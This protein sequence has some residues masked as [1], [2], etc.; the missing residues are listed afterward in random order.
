MQG[1][2]GQLQIVNLYTAIH[3]TVPFVLAPLFEVK[4]KNTKFVV[5]LRFFR[6]GRQSVPNVVK[7]ATFQPS[8]NMVCNKISCNPQQHNVHDVQKDEEDRPAWD[9]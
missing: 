2:P 9:A 5:C 6:S 4:P 1:K 8:A 3:C 7:K